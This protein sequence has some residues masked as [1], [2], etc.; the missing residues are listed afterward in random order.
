MF[1][2]R[3]AIFPQD[4]YNILDIYR[5]YINSASVSLDFQYNESEFSNLSKK[6]NTDGAGIYLICDGHNVVGCVAYRNIDDNICE[7]KRVYV[8]PCARGNNLGAKLVDKILKEAKCSGYRKICLDVLPEFKTAIN[9]YE[10]YGFSSDVAITFNP[11]P[12]TKF[13]SLDLSED[14]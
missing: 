14:A 4:L 5:E 9:L 8:R 7:M 3:R 11:V 12:G 10:S 13:L 2:L 1:E 6:Y